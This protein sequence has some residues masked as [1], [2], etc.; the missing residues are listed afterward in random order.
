MIRYF[1]IT[2]TAMI[3]MWHIFLDLPILDATLRS[4][5]RQS[6]SFVPYGEEKDS[7]RNILAVKD[8]ES[9]RYYWLHRIWIIR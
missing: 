4:D 1:I 7:G 6:T 3:A 2:N 9:R 5:Q 8:K